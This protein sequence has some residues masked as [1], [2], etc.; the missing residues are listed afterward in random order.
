MNYARIFLGGIVG[1]IAYTLVSTLVNML[2]LGARYELLQ[3]AKVYRADPRLPFLPIYILVL[4]VI[5]TGLVWL[6]AAARTRL[7]A[8]PR[9]ALTI[10]LAVGLVAAVPHALAQYCWSYAGG[11]VSLWQG[12]ETI[13]G[14]MVA[15]LVGGWMYRES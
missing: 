8:G 15:T 5:S 11:F 13:A 2:A 6:Y 9:T 10:G 3:T 12:I 1:G 4:V 14:S 7:G